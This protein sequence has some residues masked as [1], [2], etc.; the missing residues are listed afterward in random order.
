MSLESD[1]EE[2]WSSF[3]TNP[4]WVGAARN[5]AALREFAAAAAANFK[6]LAARID[7][8]AELPPPRATPS[9]CTAAT[10]ARVPWPGEPAATAYR[11]R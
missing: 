11:M 3:L 9:G 6:M 1:V 5:D 4:D 7:A 8:L 2:F 10:R